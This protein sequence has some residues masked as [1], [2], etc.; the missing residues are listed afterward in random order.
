M[1][2]PFFMRSC[3]VPQTLTGAWMVECRTFAHSH[4]H[5]HLGSKRMDVPA[6]LDAAPFGELLQY[7]CSQTNLMFDP[8]PGDP[9]LFA[10]RKK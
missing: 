6:A 8:P 7:F 1:R 2:R 3:D 4:S 9:A 10:A 5:V